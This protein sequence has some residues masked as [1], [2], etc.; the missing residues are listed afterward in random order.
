MEYYD[1]DAFDF[2]DLPPDLLDFPEEEEAPAFVRETD[3]SLQHTGIV[4]E[5]VAD[6]YAVGVLEVRQDPFTG[7][8]S[9]AYLHLAD[10]PHFERASE[11]R[12]NLYT[13]ADEADISDPDFGDFAHGLIKGRGTWQPMTET[14]WQLT[15]PA[16]EPPDFMEDA[17]WEAKDRQLREVFALTAREDPLREAGLQAEGFDPLTHPPPLFDESTGTAYWIGVYQPAEDTQ[18]ITSLLSI[19][20]DDTAHLAPVAI[21]DY[22]HAYRTADYLLAVAERTQDI[23]QVLDAAEGMAVATQQRGFWEN[24]QGIPVEEVSGFSPM[25]IGS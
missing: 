11:M 7:E 4:I 15:E 18:A 22:D 20:P 23:G 25:E 3:W 12:D 5:E 14:H 2:D 13:L 6:H 21:G 9:G 16:A 10:A 8:Q 19:G 1:D 24:P 17:A